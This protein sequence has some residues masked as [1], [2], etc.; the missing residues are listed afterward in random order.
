M[1]DFDQNFEAFWVQKK[2]KMMFISKNRNVLIGVFAFMSFFWQ[3]LVYELWSILYLTVV[4]SELGTCKK[5]G[6][7]FCE[8]DSL[9]NQLLLGCSVSSDRAD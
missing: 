1:I 2:S 7:H 4:N 5:S 8:P 3:F 9:A 6:R